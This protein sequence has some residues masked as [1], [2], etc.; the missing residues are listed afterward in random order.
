MAMTPPLPGDQGYKGI[1]IAGDGIDMYPDPAKVLMVN[2]AKTLTDAQKAWD[3]S[4]NKIEGFA[5]K[6]GDGPMGKPFKEQYDPAWKAINKF[7]PQQLE[8]LESLSKSGTDAPPL[9]EK[10]DLA[11]GQQ[12]EF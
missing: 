2:I 12:F 10:Q 8:R 11:A 4:S 9:Y 5:G 7:V 6:L 1:D 3:T